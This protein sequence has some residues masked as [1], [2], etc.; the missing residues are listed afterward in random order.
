[1]PPPD[2]PRHHS[3]YRRE[4]TELVE[5]ACLTIAVTLG[6]LMDQLCIV[7]GLVPWN[8]PDFAECG[9]LAAKARR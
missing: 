9:L 3:G 8:S 2:K 4:Q 6:A 5:A 1:M 7:G